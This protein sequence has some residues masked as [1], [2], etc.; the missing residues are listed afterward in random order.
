M[1]PAIRAGSRPAEPPTDGREAARA[2]W[3][4][5]CK[6]VSPPARAASTRPPLVRPSLPMPLS[7]LGP[8]RGP[9]KTAFRLFHLW[10]LLAV[11]APG[12]APA[13][14]VADA[15]SGIATA[16][17]GA[18]D[19]APVSLAVRW[20]RPLGVGY[21]GVALAAGRAVTMSTE[22]GQEVVSALDV[23]TGATLWSHPVGAAFPASG[24]SEGGAKS[25]PLVDAD[26]VYALGPHGDLVALRLHDGAEVWRV[27]LRDQLGAAP[28]EFGFATSPLVVGDLLIVQTGGAG[29]RSTTAFAKDTGEVRWT[30]GDDPS[31]YASPITADLAGVRQIVTATR[32]TVSGL[33]PQ[34]GA[35]LWSIAPETGVVSRPVLLGDDRV[36]LPGASRAVALRVVRGPDGL[37]AEPIWETRA[38]RG[39]YAAPVAHDGFVY[40][41]SGEFLTCISAEDGT[42][43]WKSREPGGRG[44][45]LV[46][47]HLVLFGRGGKV[48]VAAASPSGYREAA[49]TGVLDRTGYTYPSFGDGL[50]VVRNTRGIAAVAVEPGGRTHDAART[51]RE[52]AR[53]LPLAVLSTVHGVEEWVFERFNPRARPGGDESAESGE[54]AAADFVDDLVDAGGSRRFRTDGRG[55]YGLALVYLPP[56][57]FER[58]SPEVRVVVY[59]PST[60][61]DLETLAAVLAAP[62]PPLP[63]DSIAF[64]STIAS[65][66]GAPGPVLV[67]SGAPGGPF[68]WSESA[69]AGST[70]GPIRSIGA[71]APVAVEAGVYEL[72]AGR[73]ELGGAT[74]A[75][76]LGEAG[77]VTGATILSEK[78]RG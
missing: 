56:G 31:D 65:H 29:G 34:T 42:P 40:G 5:A 57:G 1:F 27:Q 68:T 41:Y 51:V 64:A 26:T 14:L 19:A 59:Y 66:T 22:A 52:L 12:P 2:V 46:D 69:L 36:L 45:I 39:S 21:A 43:R 38:L 10:L 50:I 67:S 28:P 49:R 75:Q 25:A 35:P 73:F 61:T 30:S 11:P 48:V 23:A 33:D 18:F 7:A 76:G 53:T 63:E 70:V 55:S 71:A 24:G 15:S 20:S 47:G 8:G 44:L 37:V 13:P 4:V 77:L 54:D 72:D 17:R 16:A 32:S 62:G 58:G 3:S 74:Y 6:V 60:I 9:L 78:A